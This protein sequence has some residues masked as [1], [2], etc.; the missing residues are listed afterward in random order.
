[1]RYSIGF[2]NSILKKVLPPENRTIRSVAK[3]A[4]ISPISIRLWL[5]KL[6][7]GSLSLN[8]SEREPLPTAI[9]FKE[10]LKLLL[11]SKTL[12]EDQIGEWLR[13]HGL[14]SQHLNMWEQELEGV[15]TSKQDETKKENVALKKENKTL[16]RELA[17]SQAAM[18]EALAL[19]TLKKKAQNIFNSIEE[20]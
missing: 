11:E 20:Q 9:G 17:R 18:A 12:S 19:I 13:Q 8:E 14:H 7:T 4:G 16:K 6:E 1:L 3:E 10:K 2:K 5:S 15:M